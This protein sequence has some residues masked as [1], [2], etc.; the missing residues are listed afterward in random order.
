[1]EGAVQTALPTVKK[2]KLDLLTLS[3]FHQ[4]QLL[5]RGLS[6]ER[7]RENRY[8][9]MPASY[10]ARK[11]IAA[12][13]SAS[14]PL[15][16]VPG[17]YLRDGAW[18]FAGNGGY[19]IPIYNK[20]GYIQG[21]QIRSDR[22]E[23]GMKYRWFSSN[24][25]K[26]FTLGTKAQTWIHVTGDAQSKVA[27][28]TEGGLKGDVASYFLGDALFVCVPG[29]NSLRYLPE[30]LNG[31][32]DPWDYCQK[33]EELF[34]LYKRCA[35]RKQVEG[36]TD[37]FF[38]RME[39][40]PISI[41]GKLFFVPRTHMQEVTLFEDFIEALNANNQNSGQLIVNSMYVLD[42]QKQRNKMAQE[43]YIAMRWEVELYQERV[44]H[45]IDTNITSPAVMNRWIA[46]IEAL[47]DKRR[48]Y[49]G[50]LRRQLDDLNDEFSTLQMFSL[51]VRV[52]R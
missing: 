25:A 29:V 36:L 48:H 5:K 26:G 47:E 22:A 17:F 1:M 27:C 15:K 7:I 45:F 50:I 20:D 8:R 23:G 42:D 34:G 18:T 21:M 10:S 52:Q 44:K 32:V 49:E 46:K 35:T 12:K 3:D 43:F 40:L 4:K 24:P 9:S 51:Q 13:L 2:A 39:A 19:L 28:V 37:L 30:T 38:A 11:R 33:A 16:G 14:Y 31:L 6:L 41:H